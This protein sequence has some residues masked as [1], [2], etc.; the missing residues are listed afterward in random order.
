MGWAPAH[1][2]DDET[3][4]T[5]VELLIVVVVIGILATITLS[6]A[7]PKWRERTYFSKATAE[8]TMLANAV[9]LYVNKYNDYPADAIR[10]LPAGLM[11]FLQVNGQNG[12]NWP[13]APWPNSVYDWDNWPPD[14]NGPQQTYQISI[15]FCQGSDPISVCQANFPKESWV[16]NAWDQYSSVYYCISGS[17]RAHQNYPQSHPG[18]CLN[19]GT[20]KS[21]VF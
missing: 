18:Y 13:N 10:G 12:V 20:Q 6:V 19:C 15:R 11:E 5:L 14:A 7:V 2:T 17:C 21:Q 3:A 4:F 16:T 1:T 9:N 8:T